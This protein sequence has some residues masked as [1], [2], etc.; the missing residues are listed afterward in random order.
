MASS[1]GVHRPDTFTD[2]NC[3]CADEGLDRIG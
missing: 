3:F 2:Y 1:P